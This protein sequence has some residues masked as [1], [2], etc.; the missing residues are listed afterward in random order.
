MSG[1]LLILLSYS[2]LPFSPAIIFV[3]IWLIIDM[4]LCLFIKLDIPQCKCID[5]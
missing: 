4:N 1:I 2:C 5:I 3:G